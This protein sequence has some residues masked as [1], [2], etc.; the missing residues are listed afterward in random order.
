[1]NGVDKNMMYLA[2]ALVIIIVAALIIF[3]GFVLQPSGSTTVP[4]TLTTVSLP[5]TTTVVQN[6]TTATGPN[7][8]SCNGYNYSIS[9][10]YYGVIGSCNWRGGL[11]NVT[12]FGGGFGASTIQI[13]EQN[14]TTTPFNTS[15][16]G[17]PCSQHSPEVV[18]M[19]PGNYKVSFSVGAPYTTSCGSATM[20]ISK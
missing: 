18:Y 13:V 5:V 2:G 16:S 11:V 3:S 15:I 1:M 8:A 17:V 12:L 6:I 7:L 20:R 10:A 9:Q 19:P 14:V 4:Q